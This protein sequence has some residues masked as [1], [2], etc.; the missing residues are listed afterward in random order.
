MDI[1]TKTSLR[2]SLYM[3]DWIQSKVHKP[4]PF[5]ILEIA[6]SIATIFKKRGTPDVKWDQLICKK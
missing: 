5:L 1:L 6:R 2:L 3:I 4:N